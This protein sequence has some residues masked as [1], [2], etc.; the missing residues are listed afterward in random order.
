[1]RIELAFLF[2]NRADARAALPVIDGVMA[3]SF[4]TQ[5][6]S[7]SHES[8]ADDELVFVD[9]SLDDPVLPA[10]FEAFLSWAPDGSPEPTVAPP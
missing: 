4:A 2:G 9:V 5:V 6:P 7:F 1:M 10:L 3:T 8:R